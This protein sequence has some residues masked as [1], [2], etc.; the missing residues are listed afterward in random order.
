M[1]IMSKIFI[2]NLLLLITSSIF[3]DNVINDIKQFRTGPLGVSK[4]EGLFKVQL[5]IPKDNKPLAYVD[6]NNDRK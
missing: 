1:K 6:F 4:G 5:G 2:I 3:A